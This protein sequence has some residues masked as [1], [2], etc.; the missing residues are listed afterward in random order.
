MPVHALLGQGS[1]KEKTKASKLTRYSI[2]AKVRILVPAAKV[3]N[4]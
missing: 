2:N 3:T 4:C 1:R